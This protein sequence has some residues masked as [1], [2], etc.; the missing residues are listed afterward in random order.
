MQ[1][2]MRTGGQKIAGS[3]SGDEHTQQQRRVPAAVGSM[4]WQ[5]R[6]AGPV[7]EERRQSPRPRHLAHCWLD[8]PALRSASGG[9]LF[10]D[11]RI[12]GFQMQQSMALA[13]Q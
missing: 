13:P 1:E 12:R 2:P 9:D 4:E 6:P 8:S 7:P 3:W 11:H 5:Y 10:A